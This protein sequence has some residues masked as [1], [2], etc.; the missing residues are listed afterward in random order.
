MIRVPK[1]L[2]SL[3]LLVFTADMVKGEGLRVLTNEESQLVKKLNKPR[4]IILAIGINSFEDPFW[5]PLQFADSDAAQVFRFLREEANILFDAGELITSSNSQSGRGVSREHIMKAFERLNRLNL[6]EDDTVV[7]YLSTHGTI[8]YRKNKNPDEPSSYVPYFVASDTSHLNI[9]NT[10]ISRDELLEMF[11]SLRSQ[12]KALIIASCH[13]GGGK[14]QLTPEI[15]EAMKRLK[16]SPD[17]L[18]VP[19]AGKGFSIL[20]ASSWSEPAGEHQEFRQDIYTHFLLEAMRKNNGRT[21]TLTQAHDYA[22]RNT[23]AFT[24]KLQHPT[25][26]MDQSGGDPIVLSGEL[27]SKG[28]AFLYSYINTLKS[29]ELKLGGQSKGILGES[30]LA[31]PDG[32][33]RLELVD[34]VTNKVVVSRV[35]RLTAGKEYSVADLIQRRRSQYL[36]LGW[37]TG[38]FFN[39]AIRDS[40]AAEPT[41]IHSVSIRFDESL[42]LWDFLV[43]ARYTPWQS[44]NIRIGGQ[45]FPQRRSTLR[46]LLAL[47]TREP[48]QLFRVDD[49]LRTEWGFYAGPSMLRIQ[50]R[51]QGEDR[52]A[53]QA[54]DASV[55]LPGLAI[56]TNFTFHQL[57][58][59]LV[60]G[61]NAQ[62]DM[63]WNQRQIERVGHLAAQ[64]EVS[65]FVGAG[66]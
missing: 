35:I 42:S 26:Q 66:W 51:I 23:V 50:R 59:G 45:D 1:F 38:E 49:S 13:S 54:P 48:S 55:I 18:L 4:R 16:G 41:P 30:Y 21:F 7:V 57:Q 36:M 58:S 37:G 33:H 61:F 29:Y 11:L 27:G 12:R 25:I 22:T 31:I 53:A 2:L 24:K 3:I 63:Y 6:R 8:Y 5:N 20:S 62:Y 43:S 14:A 39:K 47:G 40:F 28:L 60:F 44:E 34:P 17:P 46:L 19:P 52:Q 64:G 65:A 56:G 15:Q 10:A 32:K 9:Q